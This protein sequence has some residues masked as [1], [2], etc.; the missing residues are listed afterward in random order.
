MRE[1]EFQFLFKQDEVLECIQMLNNTTI[2]PYRMDDKAY[3]AERVLHPPDSNHDVDS[4]WFRK[5]D[6]SDVADLFT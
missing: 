1:Y 6:V 5:S 4:A 2:P 3:L